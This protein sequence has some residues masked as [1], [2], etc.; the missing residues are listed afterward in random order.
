MNILRKITAVGLALGL[1]FSGAAPIGSVFAAEEGAVLTSGGWYETAYVT[2]TDLSAENA[3]VS[4]K[5]ADAEEYT[6]ISGEDKALIRQ[7]D[8]ETARVDIPGL[9][10][11]DYDIKIVTSKKEELEAKVTVMA[12]DRSGYAH[13]NRPTE[14]TPE[15][16]SYDGVGAYKDDGTPKEGADIIYVTNE[17]KNTVEY[18]GV[19]GIGKILSNAKYL[20]KPL[21]VRFI[22]K[23]DSSVWVLN[24]E[25][26]TITEN[27]EEA[28]PI[29]GLYNRFYILDSDVKKYTVNAESVW[30]FDKV[31]DPDDTD[32]Y[33]SMLDIKS[34][35]VKGYTG[36]SNI[37]LEGIG[38]DTEFVNWG[39]LFRY[40]SSVEV[41]N[42]TFSD[43]Q[44]DACTA[45]Y[46]NRVWF[47]RCTFNIGKNQCDLTDEQDKG[48]GDGSADVNSCENVTIAYCTFNGTH[49]TSLSGNSDS[50]KQ[51]NYTYHHNFYNGCK[52]RLPLARYANIHSYNNYVKGTTGTSISARASAFIF[53]EAN[54]YEDNNLAFESKE[55]SKGSGIIKSYNDVITPN[56]EGSDF[57]R[58]VDDRGE[59]VDVEAI[60]SETNQHL[61]EKLS[62]GGYINN[63]DTSPYYFYCE[64]GATAVSHLTD[65]GTAKTEA[66]S[67]SGAL[68]NDTEYVSVS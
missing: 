68:K 26:K 16:N 57:I 25:T 32:T 18:R 5:A 50:S 39:V 24:S 60:D 44:E 45:Q 13:F 66:E 59:T 58:I 28:E 12:E 8:A 36:F 20:N 55:G 42:I 47:H 2:W 7:I 31:T 33:I 51:Y 10:A 54:C 30:Q 40:C 49:K 15:D 38:T 9:S 14:S 37:T 64:E 3:E 11:G 41:K 19:K 21:I 22:G 67:Y 17:T 65:A 4:Y 46:A 29:N 52:S 35:K 27:C 1:A 56:I 62:E 34:Y 61:S 6:V 63:F 53:S 43:Y 23:I 48:D